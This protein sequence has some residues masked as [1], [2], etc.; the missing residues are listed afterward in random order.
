L[1]AGALTALVFVPFAISLVYVDACLARVNYLA[2]SGRVPEAVACY[3]LVERWRPPGVRT[4]LWYSR[5]IA[6][7]ARKSPNAADVTLAWQQGLESAIRATQN[8]EERENAWLNLAVFYGRQNDYA[9]TEQ[10]LR[11]AIA[12]AP[13][14]YKPHWLLAQVLWTGKRLDEASAEAERAADLNGG[15]DPQ[16]SRTLAQIQ[17][18]AKNPQP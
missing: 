15:K 1:I 16:V 18:A 3:Q 6:R 2:Y 17:A 7:A 8:A 10:S 11:G 9:D 12:S 14:S 4:D 5:A 13:N